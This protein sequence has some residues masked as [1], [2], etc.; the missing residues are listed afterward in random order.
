MKDLVVNELLKAGRLLMAH[1][2]LLL[3]FGIGYS[4]AFWLR[5]VAW[6]KLFNKKRVTVSNLYSL[7]MVSLLVNHLFPTKLGEVAKVYLLGREGYSSQK[8]TSTVLYSRVIDLISLLINLFLF[9]TLSI[10]YISFDWQ[11]FILPATI[12]LTISVGIVWF[13]HWQWIKKFE[14]K[15]FNY[16]AQLQVALREIKFKQL[17]KAILLTIP[18]W[19][20]EVSA[21]A[22]VVKALSLEIGL[23]PLVVVNSFT[24]M[25]QVFHITP[26]GVGTYEASMSFALSLYGVDLETGLTIAVLTHSL[27][28]IYSYLVGGLFTLRESINLMDIVRFKKKLVS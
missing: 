9:V 21:L 5:S 7:H 24:I 10:K 17:L 2:D 26:G 28:F 22:V 18:S 6:L 11:L 4:L 15:F 8:A 20:L 23:I 12:I 1:P 25:A 3:V 19:M 13:S 14:V 16:L 27:K